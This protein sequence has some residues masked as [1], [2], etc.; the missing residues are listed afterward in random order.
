MNERIKELAE[1]C[2]EQRL[3]GARFNQ[4]LFAEL[5][6]EEC[7]KKI[8]EHYVGA[9]GT[10]ASAHNSAV[11]KCEKSIRQLSSNNGNI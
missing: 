2:W 3:D 10:H 9:V 7:L 11:L 1:D 5:I 4:E 6:I 8:R